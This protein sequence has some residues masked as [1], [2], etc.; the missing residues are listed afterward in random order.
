MAPLYGV[1]QAGYK[2]IRAPKPEL[3]DLTADP[4]ELQNLY[5]TEP[6]RAQDLD[7]ALQSILD[8]SRRSARAAKENPLDQ[9]TTE[10]LQALGYLASP[11]ERSSL[12]GMDPKDGIVV[13][14][15]LDDAR[16]RAQRDDWPGAA[17]LLG[18]ILEVTP[19][20]VSARNVLGLAEFRL[21]DLEEAKRQYLASLGQQPR[22]SRVYAMLGNIELKTGRY[23]DAERYFHQALE[24]T[25]GFVEIMANLGFIELER[26]NE[27]AAEE[28][29]RKA[30]AIDPSVPRVYRRFA[31]L[32]FERGDYAKALGYYQRTLQVVPQHFEALVQAGNSARQ[33]G[34]TTAAADYYKRAGD[35]LGDSWIPP[36]NLACL[37]ATQGDPREALDL[38]GQAID[39]GFRNVRRMEEN[40][41]FSSLRSLPAYVELV[42]KVRKAESRGRRGPRADAGKLRRAEPTGGHRIQ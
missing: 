21:G 34:D 28:W 30:I 3:Y 19:G 23:Q 16:H 10:M 35:A 41:D 25:P 24:I 18:E 29:Y 6:K 27:S 40:D 11:A 4:K 12:G 17:K 13:Y 33:I 9:E 38:L 36:Y 14:N 15:K 1:R 42:A 32:Y 39:K 37:K 2:W 20:N 7:R 8:E 5:S 26:G 31:D 22:Q